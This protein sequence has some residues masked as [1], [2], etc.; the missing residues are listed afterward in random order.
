MVKPVIAFDIGGTS[1]RAALV[2]GMKVSS[3]G[4]VSTPQSKD[5]FL[6]VVCSLVEERLTVPVRGIGI[7]FPGQVK[8]GKVT[9][10]P[11]LPIN[12]FNLQKFL[13]KKFGLKVVLHNDAGCVA[14]AERAFGCKKDNFLVVTLGTGIG[15]GMVINGSEYRG[16]GFGA[17]FGHIIIRERFLEFLWQN[18]RKR[19]RSKFHTSLMSDLVSNRSKEAKVIVDD[20]A[21]YLSQGLASLITALD[22]EVVILAG[23]VRECGSKL[24]NPINKHIRKYLFLSK[25]T[26]VRWT[27]LKE[28]GILGAGLL[29]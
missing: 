27:S 2:S 23:G 12:N 26:P 16:T 13:E 7:G 18:T 8:G 6:S 11:N 5:E 29:V 22:P 4:R 15:G 14:L 17:E 24:L 19:V 9:K 3:L 20:T 10:A 28:P 25:Q 1:I 21:D